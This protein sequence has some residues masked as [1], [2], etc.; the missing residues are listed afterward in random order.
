MFF[1]V[2]FRGHN[3]TRVHSTSYASISEFLCQVCWTRERAPQL[4]ARSM[5]L[6]TNI[7][8]WN[9]EYLDLF[10]V[11]QGDMIERVISDQGSWNV[12]VMA[13]QGNCRN[14]SFFAGLLVVAIPTVEDLDHFVEEEIG[15]DYTSKDDDEREP[16]R[17][18]SGPEDNGEG[19]SLPSDLP[20]T[21]ESTGGGRPMEVGDKG[22]DV[23]SGQNDNDDDLYSR[24]SGPITD[25]ITTSNGALLGLCSDQ[26]NNVFE[27]QYFEEAVRILGAELR[28]SPCG[29]FLPHQVWGVWF[30]VER[31]L[32]DC[33]PVA[34]IADDMGLGKTHYALATLLYLKYIVDEAAAGRALPC[35]GG[36]LVAELEVVPRIF[37][38]DSES[39]I[40]QTGVQL[41]NLYLSHQ[42]N[43]NELNYTSNDPGHGKAIHLISYSSY[44]ACYKNADR[45]QGCQ[46]GIGIFDESHMAKSCA[47]QTFDSLMEIDVPCRI[48]LTGT[49]MHHTVGDWVPQTECLFTQV[50][51]QDELDSHCL[52][53]L[54]SAITE[55]IWRWGETRDANRQPLVRI[56]ELVQYD[57]CLQYTTDEANTIDQWITDAKGNK[58]N[59]IQTV[60]HEWRLACLTMY[61]PDNDVSSKDSESGEA[62]V[63][64]RQSWNRNNFP[65]RPTLRWLSEVFVPQ[66]LGPPEGGVPNKAVIFAPL[67]SQPS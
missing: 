12:A 23:A 28:E 32:T 48:Q 36:K 67:P 14:Q 49:P 62:A 31:I 20:R 37:G 8:I 17:D 63:V 46:W 54:D 5:M 47:T 57:V 30:I 50:T 65:G 22:K 53:P 1:T 52:R 11:E 59:A 10:G 43:D 66:L 40:P 45:L 13:A 42:L 61:L 15:L 7:T 27:H 41:V 64:Y 9:D 25:T 44:R 35:L 24:P 56:P 3:S 21:K 4:A 55:T 34:L 26:L 19:P 60:L 58:W 16:G 51:D 33:P 38:A 18:N 2:T 6:K 39:L 29:R